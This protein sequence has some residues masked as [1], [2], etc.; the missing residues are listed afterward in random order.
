MRRMRFDAE[1]PV[2]A[3]ARLGPGIRLMRPVP[4][5]FP[6][7]STAVLPGPT[8]SGIQNVSFSF[9]AKGVQQ[10]S[11]PDAAAPLHYAPFAILVCVATTDARPVP[12]CTFN[13]AA[14]TRLTELV[15]ARFG[16]EILDCGVS[17]TVLGQLYSATQIVA[18][19]IPDCVG[20]LALRTAEAFSALGPLPT[21]LPLLSHTCQPHLPTPQLLTVDTQEDEAMA[22][23]QIS[24][25]SGALVGVARGLEAFLRDSRQRGVW[26]PYAQSRSVRALA[27]FLGPYCGRPAEHLLLAGPVPLAEIPALIHDTGRL[28][29]RESALEGARQGAR[30]VAGPLIATRVYYG[31]GPAPEY[32][33]LSIQHAETLVVVRHHIHHLSDFPEGPEDV[34]AYLQELVFTWGVQAVCGPERL[35]PIRRSPRG[36]LIPYVHTT[37][38]VHPA[39]VRY[40][41]ER[42]H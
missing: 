23:L 16:E 18:A 6:C 32:V 30:Q 17:V 35:Q 19:Q 21:V 4:S 24:A 34:A 41:T 37:D 13:D 28:F 15:T 38:I 25:V 31:Q 20:R 1:D 3:R 42:G 5:S 11:M 29:R 33:S 39:T 14:A 8:R 22:A 40:A 27:R 2:T 10:R 26:T 7:C 9:P 36:F 12:P